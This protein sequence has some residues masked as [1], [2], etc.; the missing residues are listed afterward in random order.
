MNALH[1]KHDL[2]LAAGNMRQ[3]MQNAAA[4]FQETA[5]HRARD[6]NL[7]ASAMRQDMKFAMNSALATGEQ[8]SLCLAERF[9]MHG[10]QCRAAD[11]ARCLAVNS[12][13]V[14]SSSA[15]NRTEL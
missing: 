3:E 7:A 1:L 10:S 9:A 8:V 12:T 2:D 14:N 15:A 6:L 13:A 11:L 4:D 5:L